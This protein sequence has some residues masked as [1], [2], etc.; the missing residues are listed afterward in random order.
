MRGVVG[1]IAQR[2]RDAAARAQNQARYQ[3]R[4]ARAV[5]AR[6]AMHG[7]LRAGGRLGDA[8]Q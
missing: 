5:T 2:G 3:W 1:T 7:R 4:D 8:R 6:S